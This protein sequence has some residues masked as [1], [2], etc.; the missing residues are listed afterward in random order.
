VMTKLYQQSGPMSVVGGLTYSNKDNNIASVSGVAY[1]MIGETTP[2]TFYDSLTE[3]MMEDGFLSRFT[4]VEYTGGRPPE[5]E[6]MQMVPEPALTEQCLRI[7]MQSKTLMGNR[8]PPIN[9]SRTEE[10]AEL[11]KAF[12]KEC[13]I[14]IDKTNDESWRQMWNRAQLKMMRIA[15]LLAVGDNC[16]HPVINA[17]HTRWALD[18][19]RRDIAIMRRR[20][21]SG[22]VGTGDGVRER[23]I[24]M[25]MKE[26]FAQPVP[27]GYKVPNG[28]RE[29][30][31]VPRSYLQVRT[32]RLTCFTTA[33]NG[34][35]K[36][37]DEALRSICESGYVMEVEK[38]KQFDQYGVSGKSYRIV[39]L[40]DFS[41]ADK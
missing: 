5:N 21:E 1:S 18:L 39:N 25:L 15:G 2:G 9:V 38:T 35:T 30:G 14:E 32:A 12:T 13:D 31:I 23:K 10:A 27:I 8:A 4:I 24:I 17:D 7:M 22:D 41:V 37:L 34:A 19:I 40:P 6:H 33:R 36:A 26:Y 29:N 11:M 28:M 3:S 16:V 20:V